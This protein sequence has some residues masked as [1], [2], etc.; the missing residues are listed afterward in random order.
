MH[1]VGLGDWFNAGILKNS[2]K[3]RFIKSGG[4]IVF[5]KGNKQFTTVDFIR[6]IMKKIIKMDIDDF[7]D[8]IEDEYGI[9]M[10]REKLPYLINNSDMYYDSIMEKIYLTKNDYYDEI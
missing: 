9:L 1:H 5:Y 2:K 7:I 6:F 3:I 4:G 10:Q 8:Y